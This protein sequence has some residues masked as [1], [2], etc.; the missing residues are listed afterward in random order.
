MAKHVFGLFLGPC[1]TQRPA[2]VSVELTTHQRLS[3]FSHHHQQHCTAREPHL[4]QSHSTHHTTP[5]HT[6]HTTPHHFT[7]HCI[8]SLRTP[9]HRPA[10]THH[11]TALH[12]TGRP[13]RTTALHSSSSGCES[14]RR[15]VRS[16]NTPPQAG[17]VAHQHSNSH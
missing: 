4:R 3:R 7:P 14:F 6:T 1:A 2:I 8:T 16:T 11:S 5:H 9:R 12:A 15:P 10:T 17:H 13:T